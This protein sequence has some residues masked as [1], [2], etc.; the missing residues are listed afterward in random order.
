VFE[1][2][3][4]QAA[5]QEHL[6]RVRATHDAE[7]DVEAL[8]AQ[9][10]HVGRQAPGLKG[11]QAVG[12]PFAELHFA[13]QQL[14]EVEADRRQPEEAEVDEREVRAAGGDQQVAAAGVAVRRR[15]GCLLELVDG[16]GESLRRVQ[17]PLTQPASKEAAMSG[18]DQMSLRSAGST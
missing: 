9:A 4:G 14:A 16:C 2:Q 6:Q 5:E 18:C 17:E 3:R 1:R 15:D 11:R 13:D 7:V 12:R 10:V 8:V